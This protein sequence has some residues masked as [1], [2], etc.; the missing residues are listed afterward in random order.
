MKKALL[1]REIKKDNNRGGSGGV[2]CYDVKEVNLGPK[3]SFG[4]SALSQDRFGVLGS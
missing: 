3:L 4:L 2:S 1:R